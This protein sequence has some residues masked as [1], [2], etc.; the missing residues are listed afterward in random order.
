MNQYLKIGMQVRTIDYLGMQTII[1]I[2]ELNDTIVTKDSF[3]RCRKSS[4]GITKHN[5]VKV[6]KNDPIEY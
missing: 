1:S 2:D 4:E 3:G 5:W 6:V